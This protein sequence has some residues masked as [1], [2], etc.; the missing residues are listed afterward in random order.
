M[1]ITI[2][3]KFD[4][5]DYD[6]EIALTRTIVFDYYKHLV[7]EMAFSNYSLE[8]KAGFERCFDLVYK[9]D[10]FTIDHFINNYDFMLWLTDRE[11]ENAKQEY[12]QQL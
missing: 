12:E 1:Y 2:N 4:G 3:Y 8:K 9:E 6:Y 5:N 11:F 10:V 7:G